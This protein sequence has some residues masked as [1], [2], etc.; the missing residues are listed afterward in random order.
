MLTAKMLDYTGKITLFVVSKAL[1][2]NFIEQ[3]LGIIQTQYILRD[4]ILR[5]V[6]DS[7]RPI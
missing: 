2:A 4:S 6:K 1:S 3:T 7:R 5:I